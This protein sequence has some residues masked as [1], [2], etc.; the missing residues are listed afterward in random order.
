M[1]VLCSVLL[2]MN[3]WRSLAVFVMNRMVLGKQGD[4]L[5]SV[6]GCRRRRIVQCRAAVGRKVCLRKESSR[7]CAERED[8]AGRRTLCVSVHNLHKAKPS[9]LL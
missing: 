8:R 1:L 9:Q 4:Q 3:L 7:C 2:Y 6:I 5:Y